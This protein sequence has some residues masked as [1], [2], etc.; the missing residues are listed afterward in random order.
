KAK[1]KQ[2][3][4]PFEFD[5]NEIVDIKQDDLQRRPEGQQY[6]IKPRNN[7]PIRQ[8]AIHSKVERSKHQIT[9]LLSE[10]Q[11]KMPELEEKWGEGMRKRTE[12]RKRYGFI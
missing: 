1:K 5:E 12:G 3:K 4:G 10:A 6:I 2:R 8:T 9:Y 7:M 11:E